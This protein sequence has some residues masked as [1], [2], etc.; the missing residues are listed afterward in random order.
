[1]YSNILIATDG[2]ECSDKAV[3]QGIELAKAC[4]GKVHIVTVTEP[5]NSLGDEQHMFAGLPDPMRKQ[6]IDFLFE[7]THKTLEKA[8]KSA[9]AAGVEWTTASL[10]NAHPYDAIIEA[11][12]AADCDLIVVGSHGRRGLSRL[13]LGSEATKVLTHSKRPVLVCR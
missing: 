12:D 8:A 5:F 1:M 7:A 9:D 11:A 10:E 2:S 6:A 13:L 3:A 4:K